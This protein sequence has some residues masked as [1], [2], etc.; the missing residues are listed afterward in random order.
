VRAASNADAASDTAL[1][2]DSE[3]DA[4]T[5][6][7]RLVPARPLNWNEARSLAERQAG[8]LID[9]M[10]L[11]EP[12]IPMFVVS[13]LP[14]IL[15]EWK[16]DWPV[17][18]MS[19]RVG[20]HW[21]IVLRAEEPRQR[22]RFSLGHEFKHVLDHPTI[23]ATQ[24]H[25][26]PHRR[27][28]RAERLCNYFA[29]CLLMPR[30][31]GQARFLR[32]T[33][34]RQG[35]GA[36][37]LRER[38]GHDQPAQRAWPD[39]VSAAASQRETDDGSWRTGMSQRALL[40]LRVS[41]HSQLT[42]YGDDGLSIDGQREQCGRKAAELG[43]ELVGEYIERAESA[44]TDDRPALNRMLAR[45]KEQ[46]DIDYVILWKVDR[47]ARNRR[48]DANM[49]FDIELAG[50]TL[51]SATENIDKT[52][53][54]RLMH[55]MLASFAEYYSGNLAAEVVN[56]ATQK[57]KRG[58]TPG[59]APIG[60]I[61]IIERADG[62]DIRTVA[63]DE[64][65]SPLVQWAFETYATGHYSLADLVNLLE[66]RGLRSKGNRRYGP[67]P[68]N[69]ASIHRML[70]NPYYV[71][72]V[73]YKGKHCPGRHPRLVTQETSIACRWCFRLTTAA[74]NG[75]ASNRII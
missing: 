63:L 53:A 72:T 43:A 14:G 61:N 35:T 27:Q 46:R 62:R 5:V 17:S 54:G 47:F 19:V 28:P 26:K 55:G 16:E 74:A 39:V 44:K 15:V 45:I 24:T 2:M 34:E 52:P 49:L 65:R 12:P 40:Y 13:S 22:Q 48:D 58:G 18:G 23:D 7:R 30:A 50:A 51:V 59:Q 70:T 42:D 8:E 32:R 10:H 9:L 60:F 20:S 36:A 56:G 37:L 57:A 73:T 67:K 71:G 64:Q 66:A 29:A 25:L 69:H 41:S 11:S 21:R 6:L 33:A 3:T 75:T 68:L 4:I 38:G 1:V 31:L